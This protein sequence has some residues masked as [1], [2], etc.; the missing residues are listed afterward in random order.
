MECSI[1]APQRLWGVLGLMLHAVATCSGPRALRALGP[2][3]RNRIPP[4]RAA[5]IR[6]IRIKPP[7]ATH[8]PHA[9]FATW[10]KGEHS[11]SHVYPAAGRIAAMLLE[12][13]HPSMR[14]C[15]LSARTPRSQKP[16][17]SR[18]KLCVC[19]SASDRD[20]VAVTRRQ[21]L[22]VVAAA[23]ALLA[24]SPLGDGRAQAAPPS[25]STAAPFEL[26]PLPYAL[27]RAPAFPNPMAGLGWAC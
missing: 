25:P 22:E 17:V 9:S 24:A 23:S 2:S 19:S 1:W 11:L 8:Q 13:V 26:P 4:S 10:Y 15:A 16:F 20:P 6:Y 7:W 5:G 18:S 12:V 14:P 3:G 21:T 27:G